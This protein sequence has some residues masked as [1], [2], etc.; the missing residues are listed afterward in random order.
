MSKSVK[1]TQAQT[2]D[3]VATT[4]SSIAGEISSPSLSKTERRALQGRNENAPDE[5]IEMI[6]QLAQQGGGTVLGIP[7]DATTALATLA[8]TSATRTSISVG[9]QTLQRMEDDMIQQ[10]AT[11]A[12]PAF[13]I[14][15]A[16]RRLVKTKSG[17]ALA[18]AYAQM[19]SI[20][21]NRPRKSRAK[22]TAGGASATTTPTPTQVGAAAAAAPAAPQPS[23]QAAAPKA[24]ASTSN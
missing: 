18:P 22:S 24:V 20:V 16:L 7:F 2:P 10:R 21:K 5:L 4:L 19:K 13:A 8:Q 11:A 17:N 3:T 12:D 9:Q 6:A 1:S 23:P 15:T 14:Y